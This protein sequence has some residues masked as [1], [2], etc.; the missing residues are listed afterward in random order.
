MLESPDYFHQLMDYLTEATIQRLKAWRRYAGEPAV[1]P[2]FGF[3]DDSI[4]LIGAEMYQEFVLPY[5]KRLREA[6][7][8]GEEPGFCHLCG[9]ATRHYPLIQQELNIGTFDTGFPVDH[10]ALIRQLRPG[11]VIQG[12]VPAELVLRGTPEE[13]RTASRRIIES[14]KPLSRQFV[15][16]EGNDVPPGTPLENMWALYEAGREFG[17]F[18]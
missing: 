6:L 13:I 15:F 12:G 14:V 10:A 11:T 18:E 1:S 9:N 4:Q 16:R 8:T 7:S 17:R 2:Y 3:A 5:H